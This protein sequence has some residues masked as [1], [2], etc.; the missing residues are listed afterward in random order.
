M[1]YNDIPE[2]IADL[3]VA[4]L[5]NQS[6]MT[7]ETPTGV[8]GWSDSGYDGRRSYLQTSLDEAVALA[9]QQRMIAWSMVEWDV[10]T[11][12]TGHSPFLTQPQ[13]LAN[14]IMQ[15]IGKFGAKDLSNV[16]VAV[17]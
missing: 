10:T 2:G 7:F 4:Q 17:S 3:A 14:W 8:P 9:D 15:E 5:K 12:K 6:I 13:Q 11:F 16:S 1:F